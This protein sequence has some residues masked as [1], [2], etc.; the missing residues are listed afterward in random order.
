MSESLFNHITSYYTAGCL[1]IQEF[2][3][4]A[5]LKLNYYPITSPQLVCISGKNGTLRSRP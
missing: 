1:I 5:R 3:N 2:Y 4:Q